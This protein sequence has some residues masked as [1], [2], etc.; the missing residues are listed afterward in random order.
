MIQLH[1]S[2]RNTSFQ[3]TLRTVPTALLA[4]LMSSFMPL[5]PVFKKW[6][7]TTFLHLFKW[8]G[9]YTNAMFQIL[10]NSWLRHDLDLTLMFKSASCQILFTASIT[11][12]LKIS[13]SCP[14]VSVFVNDLTGQRLFYQGW[15]FR[16][17]HNM[18]QLHSNCCSQPLELSGIRKHPVTAWQDHCCFIKFQLQDWYSKRL[19]FPLESWD[20]LKD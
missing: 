17:I 6:N 18:F 11:G 15:T 4:S 10:G 2:F 13:P 19:G 1:S 20:W 9:L 5:P 7:I 16:G 14:W 8:L 12:E 3:D